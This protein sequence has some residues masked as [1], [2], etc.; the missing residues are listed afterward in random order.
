MDHPLFV[1]WAFQHGS[2]RRRAR[3]LEEAFRKCLRDICLPARGSVHELQADIAGAVQL[4]RLNL[5]VQVVM[6]PADR[7]ALRMYL[8]QFFEAEFHLKPGW[9]KLI[10]DINTDEDLS[11]QALG[12]LSREWMR[13]RMQS[14]RP[15]DARPSMWPIDMAPSTP[16]HP[17]GVME[18]QP[19][20]EW[21]PATLACA[22]APDLA[23]DDFQTAL[24]AKAAQAR[25]R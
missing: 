19:R 17:R 25:S 7:T 22:D 20:Q 10:L 3:K 4:V 18:L 24:A 11:A 15:A 13:V 21:Q 1:R 16:M 2:R 23:L 9:L 6:T 12:D 8:T 5:P 14:Y